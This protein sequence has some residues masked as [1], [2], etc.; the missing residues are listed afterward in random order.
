MPSSFDLRDVEGSNYV[1]GVREQTGG[2][3][4]T[5]GVM[6]SMESN[7]LVTKNWKNDIISTGKAAEYLYTELRKTSQLLNEIDKI[8][9]GEV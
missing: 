9:M 3:C 4:W 2:T 1:T 5:H 8:F 7:L 6:A